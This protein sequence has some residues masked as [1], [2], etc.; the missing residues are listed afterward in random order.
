MTEQIPL[1]EDPPPADSW[2]SNKD[3]LES[4]AK[5]FDSAA[6][7]KQKRSFV[8]KLAN[9]NAAITIGR[10]V[11][12]SPKWTEWQVRNVIPHE[13][14]GHVRQYRYCGFGIHPNAGIPIFLVLYGLV[15]FPILLAWVRYRFELHAETQ[16]WNYRLEQGQT[17][18]NDVRTGAEKFAIKIASAMYWFAI[19]KPWVL[20]GFKRRAEAVIA[21]HV[22][23]KHA[24]DS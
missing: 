22:T 4:F 1:P 16:E 17:A 14:G 10:T 19:A 3:R 6:R 21:D 5:T 11:W 7:L 15:F 12:L 20:W 9:E 8:W 18:P 23:N 2:L 24:A 13:V